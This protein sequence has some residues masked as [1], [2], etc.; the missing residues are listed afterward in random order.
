[1]RN[2]ARPIGEDAHD[3]SPVASHDP[4]AVPESRPPDH[5][6]PVTDDRQSHIVNQDAE[7]EAQRVDEIDGDVDRD[8]RVNRGGV[9]DDPTMPTGDS[10]L[11]TKI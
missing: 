4:K 10:T 7:A 2:D 5:R 11:N 6:D 8:D 3:Q 9:N 1:M